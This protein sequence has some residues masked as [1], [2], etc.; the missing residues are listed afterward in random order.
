MSTRLSTVAKEGYTSPNSNENPAGAST[1]G[2]LEWD[3]FQGYL[4]A[5]A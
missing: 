2:I 4:T 1:A 5:F 3:S